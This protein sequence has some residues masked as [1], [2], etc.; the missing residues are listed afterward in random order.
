MY[1]IELILALCF[2]GTSHA[3]NF[4]PK[5]ALWKFISSRARDSIVERA[6]KIDVDFEGSVAELQANIVELETHYDSFMT[7]NMIW[8]SYYLKEFHAYEEG[9]LSWESAMEVESAALAVHAPIFTGTNSILRR[10]G[11]DSLRQ[12]YHDRML[13][14][15]NERSFL[16][17][18]IV[19]IGCSTGLST[20]KL[21][22]TFPDAEITGVDLSP[23]MLAV[24]EHKKSMK[25][26]E[27]T[28]S[29]IRYAFGS[30]ED[31]API[32]SASV[33]LAS[34][35]LV[36]HEL[37]Q[38]ATAE[39]FN[40]VFTIL[41][42]GCPL[43]IMDINPESEFFK[44]FRSNRFAFYGFKSTEPHLEEYIE[45][46]LVGKLKEAGFRDINVT[47]NSPRHRTVT[48]WKP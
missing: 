36:S 26:W 46:D 8:P 15:L 6:R 39:I 1:L 34:M 19:D 18:N 41:K 31:L 45:M 5:R 3:L 24:A 40:E 33:D 28:G 38:S 37:P 20:L 25:D 14:A 4:Q 29:R 16:P 30:G 9:N 7:P 44:K 43:C 17:K 23:Y 21:A 27:S 11:D 35:C 22:E 42:N 48:G 13:D 47:A 2:F 32:L 12:S 10:D